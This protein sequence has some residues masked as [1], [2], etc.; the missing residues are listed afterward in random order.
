MQLPTPSGRAAL[1]VA[2]PSHELRIHGWL[3]QSQPYVCILTDGG[4]RSGEPRLSRTTEVLN[5][6]GARPGVIYGRLSDLEVYSA[7]LNGDSELFAGLVEELCDAFVSEQIE[8][9]VGDAAEGYSVAHDICRTIIGAAVDLAELKHDHTI[10]N[11]DFLV[12]GRP[13]QS[14]SDEAITLHLD[15]DA[16]TRKIK[17]ALAYT[18]K[19]A[20]DVEAALEGAPFQGVRRFSEPQ[21][22]GEVDV[23]VSKALLGALEPHPQL[24]AK[25]SDIIEGVPL[26]AFRVECL[27]PVSNESGTTWTTGEPLFYELYGEKLVAAGRYDRVIRYRE[28]MLPLARAIRAKTEREEFCARFAS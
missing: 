7:I 11:F 9:V 2:H 25:L 27:R 26:D 10:K 19:L 21:L 24:K 3:E 15:H 18:P 4:G 13:E 17:A 20:K 23:E 5:R 16:F 22:A 28:H 6:A 1:V 14:A 12:V 8:Y